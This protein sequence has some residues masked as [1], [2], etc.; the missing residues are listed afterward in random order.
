[1]DTTDPTN[2][3]GFWFKSSPQKLM[4][5]YSHDENKR[6]MP[7]MAQQVMFIAKPMHLAR[8]VSFDSRS[9]ICKSTVLR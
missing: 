7:R 9:L 6:K 8:K 5:A 4:T 3:R 1:M 2:T